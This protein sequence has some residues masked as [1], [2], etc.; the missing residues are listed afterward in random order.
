[1]LGFPLGSFPWFPR[2]TVGTTFPALRS[3]RGNR[4]VVISPDQSSEPGLFL[5]GIKAGWLDRD[6]CTLNDAGTSWQRGWLPIHPTGRDP[7]HFTIAAPIGRPSGWLQGSDTK[8]VTQAV[9][10]LIGKP[11][12]AFKTHTRYRSNQASRLCQASWA[13]CRL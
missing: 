11:N 12:H 3:V 1:M 7:L 6:A 5:W 8:I 4:I 9:A 2:R 10:D 13:A